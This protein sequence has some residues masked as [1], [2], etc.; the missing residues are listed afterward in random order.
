MAYRDEQRRAP[1]AV[2][3]STIARLK[4]EK[5]EA[6][7]RA[8]RERADKEV[9]LREKAIASERVERLAYELKRL[10][11]EQ[12]VKAER[13]VEQLRLQYL[14]REERLV[15]DGDRQ[16]LAD[17]K[18]DLDAIRVNIDSGNGRNAASP[19][20]PVCV[21]PAQQQEKRPETGSA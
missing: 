6:E 16:Q 8:E 19:D 7:A 20:R 14:A 17:I 11:R 13:G 15:L 5:A 1:E 12:R 2:L 21:Q 10:R 9:V 4:G 3:R 18:R